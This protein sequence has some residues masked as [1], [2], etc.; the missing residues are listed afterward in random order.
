[1]GPNH[2]PAPSPMR[3]FD[4]LRAFQETAALK[5]AIDLGVF[6][7][8]AEG[9]ATR[10]ISPSGVGGGA[11]IR[12][13]CDSL[14]TS[15]FLAKSGGE[16]SNTP[17]SAI[18]LDRRSPAYMAAC[19]VPVRSACDVGNVRE[20]DGLRSQ[21][22]TTL[23]DQAP[24][25]P[26]IHC[27]DVRPRDGA[28]RHY[29]RP[30]IASHV[31]AEGSLKVL[32]IAAPCMYGSQWHSG[33]RRRITALD[34]RPFLKSQRKMPR[35][36]SGGAANLLPGSV[37][38]GVRGRLRCGADHQ[39]PAPLRRATNESLLRKVHAALKPGGVAITLEFVPNE[40]RVSPPFRPASRSPC[41][42]HGLRR[43][44]TSPNWMRCSAAPASHR[45]CSTRSKRS[46]RYHF[47]K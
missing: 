12:I 46:N 26:R 11:G 29:K 35:G 44:L 9:A 33:I 14:T 25:S 32:D 37:R 39:L 36:R 3:I 28:A 15:E 16:Y 47:N 23:P 30:A 8:I 20:P 43:R 4:T 18:F 41:C 27:G 10:R 6:T 7:A 5:A 24:L 22:R 40:D 13:L 45:M 38:C 31:A 17:D 21:G 19:G 42:P 2:F 1:M 34:W